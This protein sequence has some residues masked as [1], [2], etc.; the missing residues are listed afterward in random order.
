[1]QRCQTI[2]GVLLS[3]SS[4]PARSNWA[5]NNVENFLTPYILFPKF[6]LPPILVGIW[7]DPTS[8]GMWFHSLEAHNWQSLE[9]S[10]P[11][12]PC[13]CGNIVKSQWHE[14]GNFSCLTV[15]NILFVIRRWPGFLNLK[16]WKS[17]SCFWVLFCI[18]I[19]WVL[20]KRGAG[21]PTLSL[22]LPLC[23]VPKLNFWWNLK[24]KFTARFFLEAR[25]WG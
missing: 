13:I 5:S 24:Q 10:I 21:N 11:C 16:P 18:P 23:E 25:M 1:M 8:N 20:E 17:G 4:G 22:I 12:L 2:V 7:G 9:I 3:L 19:G 14:H 6:Q 15:F